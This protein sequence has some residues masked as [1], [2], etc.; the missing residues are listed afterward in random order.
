MIG[1]AVQLNTAKQNATQHF[2]DSIRKHRKV[3]PN[4]VQIGC[5]SQLT[6]Q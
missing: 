2:L 3:C 5:F 1:D 4:I 6:P